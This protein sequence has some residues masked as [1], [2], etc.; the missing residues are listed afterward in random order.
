MIATLVRSRIAIAA[1]ILCGLYLGYRVQ[2]AKS[3]AASLYERTLKEAVPTSA[4]R[5]RYDLTSGSL[6]SGTVIE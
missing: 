1:V 2:E 5:N 4:R 6:P 3:D